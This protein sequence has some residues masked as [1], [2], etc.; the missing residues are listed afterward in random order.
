ME[1]EKED[2]E[3]DPNPPEGRRVSERNPFC[4]KSLHAPVASHLCKG[5]MKDHSHR[6][7]EWSLTRC[8]N[9]KVNIYCPHWTFLINKA[10]YFA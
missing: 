7:G 10:V 2:L 8:V 5:T 4:W 6:A 3:N 1:V 9:K